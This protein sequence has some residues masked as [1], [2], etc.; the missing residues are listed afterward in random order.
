VNRQDILIMKNKANKKPD[1]LCVGFERTGTTWLYKNLYVHNDVKLPPYKEVKYFY[2]GIIVP[3]SNLLRK[4]FSAHWY[5]YDLRKYIKQNAT[6]SFRKLGHSNNFK[7]LKELSRILF[8]DLRLFFYPRSISWYATLFDGYRKVTGDFSP[9]YC[10][11]PE[12]RVEKIK[13]YFPNLKII[14][15]L[16][17]QIDRTWSKAKMNLC[18]NK[19]RI[20]SEVPDE[21]FMWFFKK[22]A[23]ESYVEVIKLWEKHFDDVF[24]GFHD[25]IKENPYQ[26]MNKICNFLE[27][28]QPDP[29]FISKK[30]LNKVVNKGI[31][32]DLPNK[33]KMLLANEYIDETKELVE[34]FPNNKYLRN[35]LLMQTNIIDDVSKKTVT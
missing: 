28:S 12:D 30:K 31:E 33:F 1:F 20:L 29:K 3:K 21:K 18:S 6:N 9:L 27:I 5:F 15:F 19:N 25:E 4:V 16:R 17:N 11:L 34:L 26:F 2:E 14:I 32:A 23:G 10:L 8:W 13:R 24:V 35:W 22:T 7:D